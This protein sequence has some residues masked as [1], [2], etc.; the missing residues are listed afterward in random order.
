VLEIIVPKGAGSLVYEEILQRLI[1]YARREHENLEIIF[2]ET[3]P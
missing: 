3:G 1:E 2:K